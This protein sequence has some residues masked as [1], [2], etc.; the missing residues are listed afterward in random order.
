MPWPL[1]YQKYLFCSYDIIPI[2][3]KSLNRWLGQRK[4]CYFTGFTTRVSRLSTIYSRN[5]IFFYR[6]LTISLKQIYI[7]FMLLLVGG[8]FVFSKANYNFLKI[9]LFSA[10]NFFIWTDPSTWKSRTVERIADTL[11]CKK[12]GKKRN[13][14]QHNWFEYWRSLKF[15]STIKWP[16]K[17]VVENSECRYVWINVIQSS[18]R[19]IKS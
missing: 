10:D 18:V 12:T 5:F 17:S 15:K 1:F 6:P 16:S 19:T 14:Y 7:F 11:E 8:N 2:L 9:L 3:N 13:I 4:N